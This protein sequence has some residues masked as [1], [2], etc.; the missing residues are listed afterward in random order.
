MKKVFKK[1]IKVCAVAVFMLNAGDGFAQNAKELTA[2][3]DGYVYIIKK[4]DN[5]GKE[6]KMLVK[7]GGRIHNAFVKFDIS[8]QGG[9]NINKATLKV[10]CVDIE[11][12]SKETEVQVFRVGND[13]VEHKLTYANAPKPTKRL[14]T[15]L[16]DKKG[17]YYEWDVTSHVKQQLSAGEKEV[18]FRLS[19]QKRANNG[20]YFSTKEASANKP[21][22]TIE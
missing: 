16:V 21:L 4:D 2:V 13:W 9:A 7:R 10:Y 6:D 11:D 15:V 18:S 12:A 1:V 20:V 22:L 14:A 19:D 3:A 8:G 5:Y 17:Q